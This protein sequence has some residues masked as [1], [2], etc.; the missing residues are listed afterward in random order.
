MVR[1]IFRI[2]APFEATVALLVEIDD[3]KMNFKME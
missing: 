3:Y 1:P 2:E